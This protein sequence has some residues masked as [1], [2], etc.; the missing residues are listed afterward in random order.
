MIERIHLKSKCFCLISLVSSNVCEYL[1]DFD[2]SYELGDHHIHGV[3]I[4]NEFMD[5]VFIVLGVR[6]F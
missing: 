4:S 3:W 2:I 6:I 1:K 5:F